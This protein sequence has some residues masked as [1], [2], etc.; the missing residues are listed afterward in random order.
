[1]KPYPLTKFP[2]LL[3]TQWKDII[4]HHTWKPS[5]R[6]NN[7]ELIGK[8]YA[9]N[10]DNYH[11]DTLGWTYGLGYH[12]VIETDGSIYASERWG[13]QLHG[14]HC[15]GKNKNSIGI[16]LVGD[17]DKW[18][19]TMGQY[20]NLTALVRRL[21]IVYLIPTDRILPHRDFSE[22]TCPGTHL[23]DKWFDEFREAVSHNEFWEIGWNYT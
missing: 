17:F 5:G 20:G 23:S 9:S 16:G 15:K 22:K 6:D 11:R 10:I 12:F 7:G 19:P 4:L 13:G 3:P 18:Y 21:C 1:M 2:Q 8:R 14:A